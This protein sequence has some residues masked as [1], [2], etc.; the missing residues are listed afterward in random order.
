[1]TRDLQR[2]LDTA[3]AFFLAGE[4][5]A[6]ELRF[7]RYDFHT[8]GAPTITNY[9]LAVE[10]A[11]KL[12]HSL[13]LGN[14]EMGHN[15]AGLFER[16]PV[17]VRDHLPYLAEHVEEIAEYFVAWRYAFEKDFLIADDEHPRRAFIECY[18]EIRRLRPEL[19]SVYE[20]L[21]GGFDPAWLRAWPV[22]RPRW[23]LRLANA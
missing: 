20:E 5:C 2:Q 4:R 13:A 8:V 7:D 15:L 19:R 6:L 17:E 3:T 10:L 23:E 21:W 16:L 11:L 1:V 22:D 14:S 18:Q 12:I 9:A